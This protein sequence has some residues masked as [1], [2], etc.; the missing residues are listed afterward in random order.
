M[1]KRKPLDTG[2]KAGKRIKKKDLLGVLDRIKPGLSAKGIE[3]ESDHYLFMGDRVATCSEDVCVVAPFPIGFSCSVR[4]DEFYK[5]VSGSAS[6]EMLLERKKGELVVRSGGASFGLAY[7]EPGAAYEIVESMDHDALEWEELPKDVKDAIVLCSF[8]ASKDLSRPEMTGVRVGREEILSSDN[9]R[10]SWYWLVE[11]R[12]GGPFL[13]PAS[14]AVH[15]MGY[16]LDHYSLAESWVHFRGEDVFFSVRMLGG[17]FPQTA[18]KGFFPEEMERGFK[19]PKDLSGV[20]DRAMVL[21]QDDSLLDKVV[22]LS[23]TEDKIVC[24]VDKPDLGWFSESIAL[25]EGPRDGT[26]VDVN[27]VF[28]KEVLRRSTEVVFVDENRMVFVSENFRH[29]IALG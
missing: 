28:L 18:A 20:L 29:L 15:L 19:L 13:V 22:G 21:L 1:A 17:D 3:A 12:A 25:E 4:A 27:P 7:S 11:P 16:D 23:F 26:E 5:L 9:Y 6:D 24:R 10:I 14:G 8:S 2:S